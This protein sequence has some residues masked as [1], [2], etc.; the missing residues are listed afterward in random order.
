VRAPDRER[1]EHS[2]DGLQRLVRRARSPLF[3]SII[4]VLTLVVLVAHAAILGF[5]SAENGDDA[6]LGLLL[7]GEALPPTGI[8]PL[9]TTDAGTPLLGDCWSARVART[10][11][12]VRDRA[13]PR[14]R[15]TGCNT[16]PAPHSVLVASKYP[17]AWVVPDPVVA[18]S[19]QGAASTQKPR[20]G[21]AVTQEVAGLVTGGRNRARRAGGRSPPRL[22]T[23]IGGGVTGSAKGDSP[24]TRGG[25]R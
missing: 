25:G 1:L 8:P 15:A 20:D 13:P 9:R 16:T 5:Y 6:G 24:N 22:P 14:E 2:V 12:T 23:H 10:L 19:H 18:S 17:P 7:A 3:F 21:F 4:T 11:A